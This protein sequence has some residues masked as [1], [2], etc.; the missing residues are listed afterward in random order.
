M[1]WTT[2][3]WRMEDA[4]SVVRFASAEAMLANAALDGAKMVTSLSSSTVEVRLVAFNAP[5][6]AVRPA[7]NAVSDGDS[8]MV[9]SLSMMWM[10]PPVKLRSWRNLVSNFEQEDGRETNVQQ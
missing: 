5:T 8:G 7:A 1:P 3:Y 10:T 2:W 6:I 9:K 4:C